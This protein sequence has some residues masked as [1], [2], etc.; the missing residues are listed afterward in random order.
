MVGLTAG[1]FSIHSHKGNPLKL[2]P[3]SLKKEESGLIFSL[4]IYLK[5]IFTTTN[6]L[7]TCFKCCECQTKDAKNFYLRLSKNK[8]NKQKKLTQH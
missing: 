4:N 7:H 6:Y 5:N 1:N 3:V 8:I 2:L